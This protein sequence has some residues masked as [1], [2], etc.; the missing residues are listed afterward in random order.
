MFGKQ[1]EPVFSF[2]VAANDAVGLDPKT[3][4]VKPGDTLTQSYHMEG[5]IVRRI[6]D[7]APKPLAARTDMPGRRDKPR[8]RRRG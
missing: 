5:V 6:G 7:G 1:E 3:G 2:R 4:M 8:R